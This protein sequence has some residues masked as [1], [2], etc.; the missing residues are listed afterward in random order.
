MDGVR[1]LPDRRP[2]Y[3]FWIKGQP[4]SHQAHGSSTRYVER[5]QEEARSQIQGPPL[6]SERLDI[7]I[8]Y[9]TRGVRPDVDNVSKLILDALKGIIY[10]DDSQIRAAKTVG[11]R[12]EHGFRARG[13]DEPYKRLLRGGEFLVNVYDEVESDVYLVDSKVPV[14]EKPSVLLL[15][16]ARPVSETPVHASE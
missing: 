4:R 13:F 15:A 11:L 16:I 6:S 9:S 12:L 5:I 8:I 3:S 14:G 1:V 7:E 10:H 2:R